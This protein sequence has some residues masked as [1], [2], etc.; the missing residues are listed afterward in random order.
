MVAKTLTRRVCIVT[1]GALGS[2]PRTV[3]EAEALSG[4]G[5]KVTVISTRHRPEVDPLD[6][7]ILDT[8]DWNSIRL[9]LRTRLRRLPGKLTHTAARFAAERWDRA[10]LIDRA[11]NAATSK[12]IRVARSVPADL[13][14]AHYPAALPAAASAAARHGARYAFDAEDFHPGD[15]PD[16]PVYEPLQRALNRIERRYLPGA[17]YITAAAP[18]IASAYSKRYPV[19]LPAVILNTFP[20]DQA[21]V[22]PTPC[23]SGAP[24]P[25]LYW[26]SQTIGPD[27][28][29]ET[30][31]KAIGIAESRP[32]LYLRG[33]PQPGYLDD[34][35]ALADGHGVRDRLRI[36]DI[37]RPSR[38]VPLA[39]EFDIGLGIEAGQTANRRIA[40]TNKM[41]TYL[42][43]GV[44]ALLTD[45]PAHRD[46]QQTLGFAAK[47][48]PV[49]DARAMAARID[50]WLRNAEA[51]QA[52]RQEAWRLGQERYNWDYEAVRLRD[53][54]VTALDPDG[55]RSPTS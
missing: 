35:M 28:G 21:P 16:D 41:F 51:L 33:L 22:A 19:A 25:S 18:L 12:L 20:K 52:A 26:F 7:S 43:A 9:D 48:F 5:F 4:A 39:A 17:A 23:G 53:C 13:Y 42:L 46:L 14:I 54:V 45:I 10:F 37:D 31:V 38:M 50:E 36:L 6:D 30:A 11:F 27:R 32:Y 3:K 49:G 40:L 47:L 8:A 34:L 24:G 2:N 55:I 29:L 1:P 15:W 44:P